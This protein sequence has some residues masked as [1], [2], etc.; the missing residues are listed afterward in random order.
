[1][2]IQKDIRVP[3]L[4]RLEPMCIKYAVYR[5]NCDFGK[6]YYT[7]VI[8]VVS[9]SSHVKVSGYLELDSHVLEIHL[10]CI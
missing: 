3:H 1:M 4:F 5:I 7:G 8:H 2:D 9:L 10:L 6:Y